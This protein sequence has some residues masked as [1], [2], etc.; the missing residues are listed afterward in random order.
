MKVAYVDHAGDIGGGAQEA[1]LDILRYVDRNRVRPLLFH[2]ER[3][4]WLRGV[5]LDGIACREVFP[6]GGALYEHSREQVAGFT[7]RII[8]ALQSVGP[9]SR[10]RKTITELDP[11]IIHTNTLK[12]HVLG[13]FAARFSRKPLVW[14]VRDILPPG[15]ARNLL[16]RVA[17][18]VR[19]HIVAMSQ[20]VA[21]SLAD[22]HCDTT[23]VLGARP[24]D[25]Y[26]PVA[27]DPVLAAELQL[28]PD[29]PVLA[30]IARLTPWKG[31]RVLL[32]AMPE[33]LS[34]H[35]DT[36]LLVIGDTGF[37]EDDYKQELHTLAE[38]MGC[39]HAV[40]WLGF[41]EDVQQL[42]A[43]TDIVVLPSDTEP[44][45]M[46]LIEAM[47]A[48]KPVIATRAAGPMEIVND[49]ET[50]LLVP[51]GDAGAL[52]EA[53]CTLLADPTRAGQM[54]RAGRARA[55]EMFDISRLV[56]QLYGVYDSLSGA[57]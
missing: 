25:K 47:A 36:C 35:P 14:D 10:L 34:R 9:V 15:G 43:L 23:V 41:R 19:P 54:G 33:I 44:F 39:A 7:T 49:G 28:P 5:D 32:R 29:A 1:L 16:V 6:A 45:G 20:A 30:V 4:E 37:W 2:A 11:D 55:E 48:G 21:D 31:H 22:A 24:L 42:L 17:R 52:A 27:R 26:E 57:G 50:G 12:C 13:G 8:G 46:V 40:R 38:E 56:E 18:V 3:A 53:A 51:I